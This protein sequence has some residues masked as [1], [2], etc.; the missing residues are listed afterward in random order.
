VSYWREVG[1]DRI[2]LGGVAVA[3]LILLLAW[4]RGWI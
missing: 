4:W 2:G 1:S 3:I